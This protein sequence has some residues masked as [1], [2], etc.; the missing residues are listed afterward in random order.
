MDTGQASYAVV[1]MDQVAPVDCPCGLARRAL[2]EAT[3]GRASLHLVD[4]SADAR[5]HYHKTLTEVYL[6]LAGSGHVEV[7]GERV[8]VRPMTAVLVRP[9]CRHRAVGK[10]RIVNIVMPAFDPADE[11]V[12]D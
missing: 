11:W 7:D 8:P 2:G 3:G 4:I 1:Q 12:D 6:V 9:G 10:M 5:P